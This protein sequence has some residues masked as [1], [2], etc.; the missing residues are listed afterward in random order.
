VETAC[1]LREH[2]VVHQLFEVP[3]NGIRPLSQVRA[4]IDLTGSPDAS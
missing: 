3:I 2:P 1:E 4:P